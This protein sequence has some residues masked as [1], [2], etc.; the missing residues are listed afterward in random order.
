MAEYGLNLWDYWRII[1]KRKWII[2]SIFFISLI[3]SHFFGEKTKPVYKSTV[4]INIDTQAPVAQI[5]GT[6]VTFWNRSSD[7]FAT[8]LELIK[9]YT[10]LK[11]VGNTL[12]MLDE[13]SSL[14]RIAAIVTS[15]RAKISI[16][17]QKTTSLVNLT[18]TDYD[19]LKAREIVEAV[20]QVFIDKNWQDKVKESRN[21]KDFVEEQLSKLEKNN[22]MIRKKL[23]SVGVSPDSR[24]IPTENIDIRTRLAH[25]KM[26]LANLRARYTDNYPG[27]T[28][29]LTEIGNIKAQ[30]DTETL[31]EDESIDELYGIDESITPLDA[32]MLE[33]Q[34]AIN[35]RLYGILRERY[36]KANLMEASQ[37][38]SIEIVNPA[39]I[40]RTPDVAPEAANMFLGGLIG[41]VLGLVAA[42]ITESMDTSIG[43]IED[44]EEYLQTP[45][46]GVIPRIELRKKEMQIDFWKKPPPPEERKQLIE[47]MGRL[48]TQYHPKSPI[49]EAYRNLQTY[50]RFS[51]IDKVGNCLM[52][53]SAGVQE[54]KTITS[55][56]SALSMA[57]L[58]YKVLLIDADLRRPSVHKVFGIDRAMGLTEVVLGT[59]KLEDVVKNI[60]DIMMGNIKSSMVLETYG[61]ENLS[62]LTTGHLPSNPT[63]IISSS[64]MSEFI[65]DVKSRYQ[66][67]IFDTAPI[68]PVTD[69]C[70]LSSKLDGAILVYE[71]GRVSRGALRRA[72]LQ[73]ENAQGKPIGVVLNGMRASDMRFGSPF[74][75]YYQK[76]YGESTDE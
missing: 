46:L 68:L 14:E 34:L 25:L 51:G 61:M 66:V 32:E 52:F 50:I 15:L 5:T 76:Y 23:E 45:V 21:T 26:E 63:E 28:N 29:I 10:I 16:S 41:I 3:S 40:P 12:G 75:Y 62:I 70:I 43:T 60:D 42:L 37:S 72:K 54:G 9:S 13:E 4:T 71:V 59:F 39:S 73:I 47:V 69:S 2:I 55:V 56:N 58:G 27:I 38:K 18:A 17:K 1:H 6:G 67:V 36:E 8:Q 22:L 53:T 33:N 31:S 35:Q 48:I 65:K 24:K 7:G 64:N 19:P 11:E 49:S 20:T 30:M 57:Q 74:Y 44:V